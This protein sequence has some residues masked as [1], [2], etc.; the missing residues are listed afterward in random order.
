MGMK[1]K[2]DL[3]LEE[4]KRLF[5]I[6]DEKL[7]WKID[8]G[9]R[10]K[11]NHIAGSKGHKYYQVGYCSKLYTVHRIMYMLYHDV[12]LDS[13]SAVDHID[14]NSLNNSISNLRIST[15]MQN[16]WNRQAK[17][18]THWVRRKKLKNGNMSEIPYW[19]LFIRTNGDRFIKLFPYCEDG[20]KSAEVLRETILL[21]DRKE[22]T[23]R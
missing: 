17:H 8:I 21:R 18:I 1:V 14:R 9:Y 5:Y 15:V 23:C 20:L 2:N 3:P 10:I 22:F 16:N 19:K 13:S 6:Q 12:Q 7:Y 11:A 4:L